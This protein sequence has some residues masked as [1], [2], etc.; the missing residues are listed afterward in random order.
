MLKAKLGDYHILVT[1]VNVEELRSGIANFQ[2]LSVKISTLVR[3]YLK[4]VFTQKPEDIFGQEK[5]PR[6]TCCTSVLDLE[7]LETSAFSQMPIKDQADSVFSFEANKG[8]AKVGN[9]HLPLKSNQAGFPNN[10]F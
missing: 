9:I 1:T 5:Y 10:A 2:C 4:T 7:G 8:I 3:G 6:L